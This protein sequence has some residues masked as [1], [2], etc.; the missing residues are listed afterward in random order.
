M[1]GIWCFLSTCLLNQWANFYV[2]L[3]KSLMSNLCSLNYKVGIMI[4]MS[5]HRC[6]IKWDYAL[7]VKSFLI[8]MFYCYYYKC[9][10]S[11][12]RAWHLCPNSGWFQADLVNWK[13]ACI[14]LPRSCPISMCFFALQIIYSSDDGF[15]VSFLDDAYMMRIDFGLDSTQHGVAYSTEKM[16]VISYLIL[17]IVGRDLYGQES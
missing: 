16:M 13:H 6:R 1:P 4:L 12:D 5:Q 7:F 11:W 3:S 10:L 2:M 17:K 14:F 9:S 8:V 15:Y